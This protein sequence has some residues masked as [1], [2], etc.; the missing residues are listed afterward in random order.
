MTVRFDTSDYRR[1]HGKQPKGWGVWAFT[2]ST[3][4]GADGEFWFTPHAM[5]YAN[6]KVAAAA[7]AKRQAEAAG[8]R[9]VCVSVGP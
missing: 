7:E 2:F 9:A 8:F 1:S 3:D 6:A 4:G 5:S